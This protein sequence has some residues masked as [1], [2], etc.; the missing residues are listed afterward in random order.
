MNA[1]KDVFSVIWSRTI[2]IFMLLVISGHVQALIPIENL[3]L[4]DLARYYSQEE[5]DP[6]NSVFKALEKSRQS[7][8]QEKLFEAKERLAFYRS[9]IQEG[10]NLVNSC[11]RSGEIEYATSYD[12]SQALR[13]IFAHLQYRG[14]DY[15]IRALAEYAHFFN[16]SKN[17]Y[18]NLIQTMVGSSCSQNISVI[19]LSQLKKNMMARFEDN[20]YQLPNVENNPLFPSSLAQIINR[21]DAKK[22]EMHHTL[23]LFRAFCS[24]GGLSD[25][26]RLLTPLLKHPAVMSYLSLDMQGQAFSW[27]PTL[28]EV[29]KVKRSDKSAVACENLICRRVERSEFERRMP[30]M[31]GSP[32]L[33][34]DLKRLYCE[35]FKDA[36]MDFEVEESQKISEVMKQTLQNNEGSMLA[37]HF[38]AL[39]T[40]FPDFLLQS[41]KWIQAKDVAE[42]SVKRTWDEWASQQ[43]ANFSRDLYYEEPLT[44]ELVDRELYF[45]P[46]AQNFEVQID[47]NLGEFDRVNQKIGKLSAKFQIEISKPFLKWARSQWSLNTGDIKKRRESVRQKL[48]KTI[49]DDV[50]RAREQFVIAPWS[51]NLER[52]IASELLSQL[53][54][55]LG[56]GF[57]SSDREMLQIPI[58]L[59]FGAFALK[60]Q[61]YR[62]QV[63]D[64]KRKASER[65]GNR[66]LRQKQ[67][68]LVQQI[69]PEQTNAKNELKSPRP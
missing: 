61:H 60:Y 43:V 34:N 69:D 31:V 30:R 18:Q 68:Q 62:A 24:W 22:R 40:G 2:L 15:T 9:L 41:Q 10:G 27:D 47:V 63:E 12:K 37:T 48:E 46:R 33:S 16:F 25:R 49:Q 8:S 29:S 44:L 1:D 51:K 52:L 64:N 7:S 67:E 28:N 54:L 56:R 58:Q 65:Q 55:S 13:S 26:P 20:S 53:E 45:D 11:S 38:L 66:E 32:S 42:A 4:G 21:D 17:E 59:N 5:Q 19:S 36:K 14:L 6:L 39:V 50:D 23:R 57:S 35:D 3:I